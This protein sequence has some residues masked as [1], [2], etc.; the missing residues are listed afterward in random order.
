MQFIT[1]KNWGE[2]QHYKDRHPPW[3]KLYNSLL[4][5]YDFRR[6][7]DAS[8]LHLIL[9][10]LLASQLENKVPFDPDFIA[11]SIHV[12]KPINLKLLIDKGFLIIIGEM[13]QDAS[14]PLAICL[15]R[16]RDR[17]RAETE[18]RHT[19][20]TRFWKAYPKKVGKG[21]AE[22]TW[23]KLKLD[24]KI[25][26]IMEALSWQVDSDQWN[27]DDRQYVPNPVTYLNQSRWE[28]EPP[29]PSR[30]MKRKSKW[31]TAGGDAE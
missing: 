27:K 20:F 23:A 25:D 14:K 18:Q 12:K 7:Q 9:I 3:I 2:L 1:V 28:D 30:D 10:W 31:D 5:D 13:E 4:N 24:D 17:D 11:D 22:K 26:A 6:L 16:D 19:T 8:K 29:A 21:V 15:S